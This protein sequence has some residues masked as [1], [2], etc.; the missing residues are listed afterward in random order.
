MRTILPLLMICVICASCSKYQ[1]I[2]IDSTAVKKN[3]EQEFIVDN[4]SI[5]ISYNFGGENAPINLIVENKLDVPVYVDWQ[6]SAL[7]VDDKAITYAPGTV[8]I[9]VTTTSSN[10]RW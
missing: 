5:R 10:F 4:D 3:D 6:E 8:P 9:V 7:I 1:Y 2:T